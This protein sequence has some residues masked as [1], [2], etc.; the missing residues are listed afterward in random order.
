MSLQYIISKSDEGDTFVSAFVPGVGPKAAHSS[1]PYFDAIVQGLL[2]GD[3]GVVELFDLSATAAAKFERL[4]ERV[5]LKGGKLYLDG[6]VVNNALTQQVLRFIEEGVGDWQPLVSFF[7]NVQAN[8]N[9]HSREQLYNWLAGRAFSITEDGMIVGYKGV[10]EDG[11]SIHSGRAI[12]DG[13][14]MSGHIP[15]ELGSVIE[16]PRGEVTFDPA[17]GCHYGLHVGS[18]DY[19]KSFAQGQL[20]EV[21]VNPRDVVSVPTDSDAAK[22]R[23]CRYRVVGAASYDGPVREAVRVYDREQYDLWGDGEGDGWCCGDPDDCAGGC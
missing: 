21:V 12:V 11:R 16:M 9:R 2:D 14:E 20:L 6:E 22:M 8:P 23:V 17:V 1:H 15:N 5:T 7:E 19:A 10:R 13:Q 3:E 4:S 18:F